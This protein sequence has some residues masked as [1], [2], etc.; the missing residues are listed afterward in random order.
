[1][2]VRFSL[3][4]PCA[5]VLALASCK[6]DPGEGFLSSATVDADLWKVSPAS[7]GTIAS[8]DVREGDTVRAGQILA[9]VDSVPLELKVREV[10]AALSE[11]SANVAAKVAENRVLEATHRGVV[12]EVERA[13]ALASRGAATTRSLDDAETQ[14]ET[15]AARLA[16]ARA[17]VEAMRA[18][19]GTLRSQV[20]TLR[21]QI[22][23]CRLAAPAAG[24]VL[25]RFRNAGEAAIPGRPV[26][27]I[28]RT[29]T[30]WAEFFVPQT[31]LSSLRIGRPLRLRLDD[32]AGEGWV[33]AR[34]SWI[35]SEAEFTPKGVQTRE[36]RNEL[37]FRCRALAANPSGALKRGMPVEVWE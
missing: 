35:A 5:G 8:V 24:V 31:A 1:M 16:A 33:P 25:A 26:V 4:L 22:A 12:R 3:L 37:V 20:A 29:D 2:S 28:G 34:L 6:R 10:E 9:V 15:S 30:L 21:D 27:E 13:S 23:R 18:R 17:A 32:G 36:A 7:S 14:R 11:L 19:G